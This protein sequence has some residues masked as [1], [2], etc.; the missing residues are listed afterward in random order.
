MKAITN[1]L[2]GEVSQAGHHKAFAL[3]IFLNSAYIAV[4]VVF[5]FLTDSLA[6]LADAG[7]NLSDVF[8][9]FLAWGAAYMAGR[10]PSGRR[11][12]GLRRASILA[13]LANAMILLIAI[14]AIAWE[15]VQRFADP[16]PVAG[17]TVMWVA[18]TGVL[19][20]GFTALLFMK[21]REKDLNI[22]GAFLHMAADAGV[23]LG[24]VAA[25]LMMLLTGWPW[26]DAAV[27][28]LIVVVIAAG[29]WGLLRDSLNL[30]LDA[31]PPG[32]DLEA[33]RGYLT[34]LPQVTA[35]HDL[36]IWGMS[37]TETALTAHLVRTNPR[38]DNALLVKT[39]RE[40]RERFQIVHVTLQFE[41]DDGRH[42]CLQG[43]EGAL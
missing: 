7:H 28:L 15:A 14:G 25:G 26:I 8:S 1:D 32:I 13:A 22:K 35:V 24:V 2:V 38:V 39:A 43:G 31:V 20:N 23:S 16:P 29:T 6:L 27:S 40:L 30:A 17:A 3:G 19:I 9:L 41:T 11:T 42:S 4:E 36:H 37:T 5:G 21:G 33:V 12:Y 18:G 10:P 34:S